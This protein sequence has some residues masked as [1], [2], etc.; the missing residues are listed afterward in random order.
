[1]HDHTNDKPWSCRNCGKEQSLRTEN[2]RSWYSSNGWYW[3]Q[4]HPGE[5]PVYLDLS[6]Y[7]DYESQWPDYVGTHESSPWADGSWEGSWCWALPADYFERRDIYMKLPQWE[8]TNGGERLIT[9]DEQILGYV[10]GYPGDMRKQGQ[11][12]PQDS[13][14][15]TLPGTRL[16]GLAEAKGALLVH[17]GLTAKGD[18]RR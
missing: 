6:C 13:D 4:L 15:Q 14:R 16:M 5:E 18:V 8:L 1:M 3:V 9:Y 17:L 12:R 7:Y 11:Y 2:G 10:Q